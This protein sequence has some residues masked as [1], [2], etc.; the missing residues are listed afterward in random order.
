MTCTTKRAKTSSNK[1]NE[2][3]RLYT[4]Q[5]AKRRNKTESARGQNTILLERRKIKSTAAA[6]ESRKLLRAR[7]Y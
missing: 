4:G 2:K 7:R 1:G 6:R 5:S 3:Q